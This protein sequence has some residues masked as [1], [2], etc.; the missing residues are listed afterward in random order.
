MVISKLLEWASIPVAVLAALT[1]ICT[2]AVA[3][4]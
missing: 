4:G 3:Q 1:V 2:P